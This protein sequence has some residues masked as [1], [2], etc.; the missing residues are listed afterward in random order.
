M[1]SPKSFIANWLSANINREKVNSESETPG[2]ADGQTG[3]C[4][5][6]QIASSAADADTHPKDKKQNATAL[7]S[8]S[9]LVFLVLRALL[10]C[11]FNKPTLNVSINNV[12][13]LLLL[14]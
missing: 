10:I 3:L 14:S 9:A 6:V 13:K 11:N 8:F 2:S 7:N 1:L 4:V 5:L 12:F